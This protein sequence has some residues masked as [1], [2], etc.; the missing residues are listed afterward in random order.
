MLDFIGPDLWPPNSP[1]L[2]PVDYK[3]W[4]RMQ[5]KVYE[6]RIK[7]VD[8]LKQRLVKV[9]AAERYWRGHQQ[10]EKATESMHE[11]RRTTFWTLIVSA[12]DCQ[13]SWTNK[14][15]ATLFILKKML[16][17]CWA[18]DFQGIKVS[19]GKV[20]TINRWGGILNHLSMTY[21]LSNICT[22]NYWNQT[23][24]DEIIV[25]GW[26]VSFLRQCIKLL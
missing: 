21:L 15:S 10:L 18:C 12:H 13:K 14:I 17:Y 22:K 16:L 9:V 24:T 19:Q 4:S 26:L 5:Q 25:G 23:T 1:D 11:C 7:S 2:N 20:R 3:V 6:C 8:E